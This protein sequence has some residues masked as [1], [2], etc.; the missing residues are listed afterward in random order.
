[1][2]HFGAGEHSAQDQQPVGMP[3]FLDSRAYRIVTVGRIAGTE[4]AAY[5]VTAAVA[6]VEAVPTTR[7]LSALKISKL[8]VI[9]V[10]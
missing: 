4:S 5:S 10:Y 2:Y 6:L 3:S 1:M 7:S 8:D 9:N